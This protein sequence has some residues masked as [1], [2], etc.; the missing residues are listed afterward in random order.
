MSCYNLCGIELSYFLLCQLITLYPESIVQHI[1]I[2][3][4]KNVGIRI[5]KQVPLHF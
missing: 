2:M 4:G 1:D 5:L 3:C